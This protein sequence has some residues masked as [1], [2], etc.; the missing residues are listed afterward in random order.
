M[1]QILQMETEL[2]LDSP[3][4]ED[5][6]CVMT[7]VVEVVHAGRRPTIDILWLLAG[8]CNVLNL[9]ATVSISVKEGRC[10][11]LHCKYKSTILNCWQLSR[12][13]VWTSIAPLPEQASVCPSSN[14]IYGSKSLFKSPCQPS[15]Q[16]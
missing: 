8:R 3:G 11:V 12:G 14:T 4:N 13:Q 1:Y 2:L 5:I 9:E 10:V 16:S 7:A 6:L 15:G